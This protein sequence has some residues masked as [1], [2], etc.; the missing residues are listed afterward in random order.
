MLLKIVY[1]GLFQNP[2]NLMTMDTNYDKMVNFANTHVDQT[3]K[4]YVIHVI[5]KEVINHN[6]F[7][8]Y[9]YQIMHLHIPV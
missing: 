7:I 4:K 3:R 2:D 8:F 5:L 1:F 6:F 9:F